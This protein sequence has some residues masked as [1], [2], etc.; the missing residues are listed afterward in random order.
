MK[1]FTEIGIVSNF[2]EPKRMQMVYY[3][4]KFLNNS[5]DDRTLCVTGKNGNLEI[6]DHL[7]RIALD[8]RKEEKKRD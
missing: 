7:A 8:T 3:T 4:S 5:W 6:F 1:G 2:S